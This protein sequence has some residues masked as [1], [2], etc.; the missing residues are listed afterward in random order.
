M[1]NRSNYYAT[2]VYPQSAPEGW[3]QILD[4]LHLRA[5]ISPLHDKDINNSDGSKKK[6][7]FHVLVMWDSLKSRNQAEEVF[8]L[9]G[10]VGVEFIQS[11]VGYARYLC[12]LDNPEKFQY[13][14][15]DVIC[16]GAVDYS[17]FI[18]RSDDVFLALSKIEDWIDNNECY[19]YRGLCMY[20][21]CT[22]KSLY[23]VVCTHTFHLSTYLR[24]K[25]ADQ[26]QVVYADFLEEI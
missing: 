18:K 19:S 6:E 7:H 1:A 26:A 24:D 3:Q 15:N 2:V 25:R 16:I 23:R 4:D 17:E 22:D 11:A 10:G 13:S 21:R 14:Q 8:N 12:H 5:L 9:I 20:F